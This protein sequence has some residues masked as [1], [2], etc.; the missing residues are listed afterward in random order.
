MVGLSLRKKVERQN[1][2]DSSGPS[3]RFKG[4]DLKYEMRH[5]FGLEELERL[6]RIFGK[7]MVRNSMPQIYCTE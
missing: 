7:K 6:V 5:R 2:L 1:R 4:M 3:V